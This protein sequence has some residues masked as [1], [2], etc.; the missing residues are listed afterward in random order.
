[1]EKKKKREEGKN[2]GGRSVKKKWIR[3][4]GE[5]SHPNPAKLYAN[6]GRRI[7]WK[8]RKKERNRER[9]P[10]PAAQDHLVAYYA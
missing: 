6:R 5:T 10:N 8:G 7:D 4:E 1:M 9:V 2:K 3:A